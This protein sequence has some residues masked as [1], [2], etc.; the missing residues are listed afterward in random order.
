MFG[1]AKLQSSVNDSVTNTMFLGMTG[2]P[3]RREAAQEIL[4]A[5]LP[6]G[7]TQ[8]LLFE[9]INAQGVIADTVFQAIINVEKGIWNVSQPNIE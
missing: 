3:T 1:T 7:L 4:N 8:D 9:T 6:T 5:S 2:H